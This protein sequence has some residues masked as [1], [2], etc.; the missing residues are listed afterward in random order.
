MM[1]ASELINRVPDMLVLYA[2]TC[3]RWGCTDGNNFLG[4][5]DARSKGTS[6]LIHMYLKKAWLPVNAPYPFPSMLVDHNTGPRSSRATVPSWAPIFPFKVQTSNLNITYGMLYFSNT[7]FMAVSKIK[8]RGL[9]NYL[10]HSQTRCGW[11]VVSNTK[12]VPLKVNIDNAKGALVE[13]ALSDCKDKRDIQHEQYRVACTMHHQVHTTHGHLSCLFRWA[14]QD[15]TPSIAESNRH[16]NRK[17]CTHG[18]LSFLLY[19]LQTSG[20]DH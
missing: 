3:C 13:R 6:R 7:R 18:I 8:I 20:K 17:S 1:C 12:G 4:D 2:L 15:V 10:Q 5:G 9:K 11:T 19:V 16:H 14:C